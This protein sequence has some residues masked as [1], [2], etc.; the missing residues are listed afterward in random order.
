MSVQ[1]NSGK[2]ANLSDGAN[3]GANVFVCLFSGGT[4]LCVCS[5]GKFSVRESGEKPEH[6]SGLTQIFILFLKTFISHRI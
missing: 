5:R 4:K 1:V 2:D 6:F 3:S